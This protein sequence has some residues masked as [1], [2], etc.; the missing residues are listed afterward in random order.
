MFEKEMV[1][2]SLMFGGGSAEG[3]TCAPGECR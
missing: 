1:R 2:A 3:V